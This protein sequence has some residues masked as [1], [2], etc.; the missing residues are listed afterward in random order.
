MN[1]KAIAFASCLLVS[2]PIFSKGLVHDHLM[3]SKHKYFVKNAKNMS[4][5]SG[6][7]AGACD[8]PIQR[9]AL[10][11][12]Q[13]DKYISVT[14]SEDGH[15]DDDNLTLKFPNNHVVSNVVSSE[16]GVE[17]SLSSAFWTGGNSIDFSFYNMT[18]ESS[19]HTTFSSRSSFEFSLE[20]D[21]EKL[22]FIIDQ[23]PDD[24]VCVL[25]KQG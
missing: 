14:F 25:D 12:T 21:K 19:G 1:K 8:A 17:H 5:F 3:S 22:R 23:Y 20:L 4:D 9:M 18:N 24:I 2:M 13:T 6:L 15:T 16:N 11:I 7:W 10:K